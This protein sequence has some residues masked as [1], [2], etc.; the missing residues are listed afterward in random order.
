[1]NKY[2]D[3][4]TRSYKKKITILYE[5]RNTMNSVHGDGSNMT[6]LLDDLEKN[7]EASGETE[8]DMCDKL[9]QTINSL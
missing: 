5:I 8:R 9:K 4:V 3:E 6:A 1:M 7:L 2:L